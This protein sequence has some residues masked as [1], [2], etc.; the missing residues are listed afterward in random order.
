MMAF[1]QHQ[2]KRLIQ[3]LQHLPENKVTSYG[4][5]AR[6][7]GLPRHARFVGKWLS[8]PTTAK[9]KLPWYRVLRSDGSIPFP[10]NTPASERFTSLLL[11]SDIPVKQ[12][13]VNWK[14]HAWLQSEA[15]ELAWLTW[16]EH[17]GILDHS[18]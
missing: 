5:L 17:M 4:Q 11:E 14:V 8:L 16:A 7:I 10:A 6:L 9:L 2:Q 18:Q 3:I 13:R 15:D 12:N 1:N